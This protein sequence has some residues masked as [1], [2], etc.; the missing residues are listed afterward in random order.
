MARMRI[1]PALLT[2]VAATGAAAESGQGPADP[3]ARTEGLQLGTYWYGAKITHE[4]L[5]GKVVL[6]EIWGS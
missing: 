4:D 2:L 6:V 3:D 5:V 1:L